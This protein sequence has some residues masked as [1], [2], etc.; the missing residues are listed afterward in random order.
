MTELSLR[1][2]FALK[3]APAVL[4]HML[5]NGIQNTALIA[6]NTYILVDMLLEIRHLSGQAL[7]NRQQMELAREFP[8]METNHGI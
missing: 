1:D 3:L 7:L 6:A 8:S 5:G 4:Q 2:E